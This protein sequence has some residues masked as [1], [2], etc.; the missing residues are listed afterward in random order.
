M[1][2][3][4]TAEFPSN[5][6]NSFK[7]RLHNPLEL[8]E[9]GWKVGVS[10]LSLP[11]A[12]R[13]MNLKNPWMCR[14]TWIEFFDAKNN[15]IYTHDFYLTLPSHS[16]QNEFPDNASNHFKIRLPQPIRLEGQG[17][18]VGLTAITLPDPTSQLPPLMKGNKAM[19]FSSWIVRNPA[20]PLT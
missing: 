12:I 20:N 13:K 2:N 4:S 7:N 9:P 16:S 11:Q 1:S 19:F 14:I 17:W 5:K 8:R 15:N 10:D 6:A 18:K 3:A